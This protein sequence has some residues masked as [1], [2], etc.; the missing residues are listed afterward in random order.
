MFVYSCKE[1]STYFTDSE[2]SAMDGVGKKDPKM[3]T[4][5]NTLFAFQYVNMT[6]NPLLLGPAMKLLLSSPH[7]LT[8][9]ANKTGLNLNVVRHIII[10]IYA[11]VNTTSYLGGQPMKTW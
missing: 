1:D 6:T 9:V 11:C 4:I 2:T 10:D 3:T 5:I 7:D 8:R